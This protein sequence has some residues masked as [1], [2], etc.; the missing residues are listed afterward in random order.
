MPNDFLNG[1]ALTA[2]QIWTVNSFK[3]EF[4]RARFVGGAPGGPS[5][6]L[7]RDRKL[8]GFIS[9]DWICGRWMKT[10]KNSIRF[11]K[12]DPVRGEGNLQI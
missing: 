9:T 2:G 1:M 10:R 4:L 6:S 5:R 3:S 8:W 11:H 7:R 12:N